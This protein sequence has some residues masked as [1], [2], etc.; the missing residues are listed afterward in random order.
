MI[1]IYD[2]PEQTKGVIE[3]FK[4]VKKESKT[5]Y[6]NVK[7]MDRFELSFSAISMDYC[8]VTLNM[9]F[10]NEVYDRA[11]QQKISIKK[12]EQKDKFIAIMMK[13]GFYELQETEIAPEGNIEFDTA[14]DPFSTYI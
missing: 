3:I 4:N 13:C 10:Y 8:K 1:L 2:K 7:I 5:A 14:D 6:Y 12:P 11:A 9:D